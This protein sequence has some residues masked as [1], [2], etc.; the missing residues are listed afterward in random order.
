[1]SFCM[2]VCW[3]CFAYINKCM[4][5]ADTSESY[6]HRAAVYCR[7]DTKG[8]GERVQKSGLWL[9]ILHAAV[10]NCLISKTVQSIL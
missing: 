8:D 5:V 10:D 7:A 1:M 3:Y 6:L 4:C 2:R 9:V